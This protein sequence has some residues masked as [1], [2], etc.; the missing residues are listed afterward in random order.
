MPL[1]EL[2]EAAR[3]IRSHHE[4]YDG[5][6]FPDNLQGEEIPLGSRILAVVNDYDGFQIGTLAEKK[7][8]PEQ[9]LTMVRQLAGKRYDPRVVDVFSKLIEKIRSG[10]AGEKMVAQDQLKPGMVLARDLVGDNGA[11][12][13]AADLTLTPQLI[14]QIQAMA[15]RH[16]KQL[17]LPVRIDV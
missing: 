12:L 9:A 1:E 14:S 11:L 8:G 17:L 6:G 7:I 2:R 10:Q 16:G 5:R 15:A 4:H 3:L 13:L